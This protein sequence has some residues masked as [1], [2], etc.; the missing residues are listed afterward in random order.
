MLIWSKCRVDDCACK[1]CLQIKLYF[2]FDL[3]FHYI[4]PTV[5]G[6]GYMAP[7]F[8]MRGYSP[9]Q[10]LHLIW[11]CSSK[12]EITLMKK[13]MRRALLC[14]LNSLNDIYILRKNLG[15]RSSCPDH[16]LVIEIAFSYIYTQFSWWEHSPLSS[17]SLS[18]LFFTLILLLTD[19]LNECHWL[20]SMLC[21][22]TFLLVEEL[23]FSFFLAVSFVLSCPIR[24][25]YNFVNSLFSLNFISSGW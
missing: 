10:Y 12:S 1:S 8:L 25:R 4:S 7:I 14:K 20:F 5:F 16:F 2:D 9:M 6:W 13:K 17:L 15:H 24:L 3:L 19:S 11:K 22:H 21:M 23:S 18:V